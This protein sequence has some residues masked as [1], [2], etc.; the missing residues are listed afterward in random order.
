MFSALGKFTVLTFGLIGSVIALIFVLIKGVAQV[1]IGVAGDAPADS[2]R[3]GWG[4]LLVGIGV[5]ASFLSIF[6]SRITSILFLIA[7]IGL[8]WVIS[9]WAVIPLVFFL[10]AA[11]FDFL[12]RSR[13]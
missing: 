11:L 3:V 6:L 4:L 13:N 5:V 7:G 9:G 2:S 1:V 12:G 8:F 10:I